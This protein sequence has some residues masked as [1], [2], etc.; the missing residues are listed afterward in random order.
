M[1]LHRSLKFSQFSL[2]SAVIF[3]TFFPIIILATLVRLGYQNFGK[4][5][6]IFN[7]FDVLELVQF[8][9][10]ITAAYRSVAYR[11]HGIDSLYNFMSVSPDYFM[12]GSTLSL[13][14]ISFYP[15]LFWPSKPDIAMGNEFG[16]KY[17]ASP[18]STVAFWNFTEGYMNFG[19]F[20]FLFVFAIFYLIAALD[21][22]LY[23]KNSLS[24]IIIYWIT[25][26]QI[27]SLEYTFAAALSGL[28]KYSITLILFLFIIRLFRIRI[29]RSVRRSLH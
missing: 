26:I 6:N 27:K 15:R 14:F 22:S 16:T 4:S 18:E 23:N 13:F 11:F 20:G 29:F 5:F 19:L 24:N 2:C 28:I 25:F 3:L 8:S 17:F 21:K 12:Y 7:I 9:E 1:R 10:I